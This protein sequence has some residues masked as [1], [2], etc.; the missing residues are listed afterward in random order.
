[1]SDYKMIKR[2]GLQIYHPAHALDKDK[3]VCDIYELERILTEGYHHNSDSIRLLLEPEA[4]PIMRADVLNFID[5]L[6]VD[7]IIDTES[8]KSYKDRL[9]KFGMKG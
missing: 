9:H 2:L 4:N 8:A 6:E 5:C 7:G 1:M 3:W